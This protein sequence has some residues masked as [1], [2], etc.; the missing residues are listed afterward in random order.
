MTEPAQQSERGSNDPAFARGLQSALQGALTQP[1]PQPEPPP[2]APAPP[3]GPKVERRTGLRLWDRPV[4]RRFL[5]TAIGLAIAVAAGWAPL[6]LMLQPSSVEAVINARLVVLRAPIEGSIEGKAMPS[7]GSAVAAGQIL[8]T[9]RNERAERGALDTL[10]EDIGRLQDE[11]PAVVARLAAAR[12]EIEAVAAQLGQFQRGRTA[13]LEAELATLD[14][15]IAIAALRR[16]EAAAKLSRS[17][18]LA[19]S[20]TISGVA[21]DETQRAARIADETLAAAKLRREQA[22]IE[23]KAMAA[24]SYLGDSYNDRPQSAQKL[25]AARTLAGD[26]ESELRTRNARFARLTQELAAVARRFELE[27]AAPIAAPVAGR[28]W[29]LLAFP[30]EQVVRGQDVARLLDCSGA[31]VTAA[32]SEEVYNTLHTGMPARF[33]VRGGDVEL[34]GLIVNLTGMAGASSNYAIAPSAL[35]KEPYRV[36]VAVPGVTG[37]SVCDIG[38][39]GRVLF[40]AAEDQPLLVR[41][42]RYLTGRLA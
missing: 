1:M 28:V 8:F 14:R 36:T 2:T 9:V 23:L 35:I 37:E 13:W 24:G 18:A 19:Q 15:D 30:G 33:M 42:M 17:L 26:L 12:A 5:K 6:Q 4:T 22:A 7:A 32:V 34:E 20:N 3:L 27:A 10:R 11:R 25:E 38:R 40:G 39:T 21:L 41:L 31:V 16:D 29:E